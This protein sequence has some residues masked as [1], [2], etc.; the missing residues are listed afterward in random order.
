L[1]KEEEMDGLEEIFIS[2]SK[3]P[4]WRVSHHPRVLSGCDKVKGEVSQLPSSSVRVLMMQIIKRRGVL[5][6]V[7]YRAI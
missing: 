7:R 3:R 5:T 4:I 6:I 2:P 1:W